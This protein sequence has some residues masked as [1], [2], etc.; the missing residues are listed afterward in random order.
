MKL[1]YALAAIVLGTAACGFATEVPVDK[2]AP[3]IEGH[4]VSAVIITQCNMLVAAYVTM[5]D[6][7]LVRFDKASGV[8]ADQALMIAKSAP[9]NE[10]IEVS[11]NGIGAKGFERKDPI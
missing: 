8:P 9:R 1:V 4:P 5:A 11:C 6:G 3:A 7:R 2:T 10:R